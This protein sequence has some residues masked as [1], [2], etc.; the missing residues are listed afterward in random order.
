MMS[1]YRRAPRST[2]PPHPLLFLDITVFESRFSKTK[3]FK[4]EILCEKNAPV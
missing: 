2:P 3:N 1:F 4:K